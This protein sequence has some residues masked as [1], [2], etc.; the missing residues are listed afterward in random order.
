MSYAS[1]S[2]IAAPSRRTSAFWLT[3]LLFIVGAWAATAQE[4]KFHLKPGAQVK[5]CAECHPD[6]EETLK[7]PFVHSPVKAGACSDCHSPH[8]SDHGKL[9]SADVKQIC[10][11]CHA[12]IRPEAAR[13]IHAPVT[14]GDCTKCH[15]PHSAKNENNLP[16]AG[17]ELCFSCH[18]EMKKELA[19][20]TFKHSPVEKS[21][22]TCHDPHAST[23]SASL[24]KSAVP[25]L[26]TTC[27]K[28]A[29][30]AFTKAH[31]GYSVAKSD[32]T[33]CHDPHGSSSR[34]TLW[35]SVHQPV[36]SKMCGQCHV[37]PGASGVVKLK[38]SGADL[39]RSC[40]VEMIN[41]T[42]SKSRIHWPVIDKTACT[43]CHNPHAS[44]TKPLL[45]H[46]EAVLCGSCHR[47]AVQ[48]QVR[49]VTPHPPVADGECS[50][51]HSAHSS[52]ATYLLANE[53]VVDLCGTCHDWQRHSTHP[54]GAKIID[55]RNKNLS[56]G[57]L[58][59]HRSHG[60]AFKHLSPYDTK[61]DLCVQ[62]HEQLKR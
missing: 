4:N 7:Q 13:S 34:G 9:L 60:A 33:S 58:S 30:P 41:A 12:D 59:C 3:V 28:V 27:H 14:A 11:E 22:M 45:K 18:A 21:C 6:F 61:T 35:A 62:C 53:N 56:L 51:C 15:D 5:A 10:T 32:C 19:A 43:N 54:I 40:H 42:M 46:S 52:N 17:N 25:A 47:D 36:A 8:A 2:R 26:C 57:C 20:N 49:S 44:K 16:V 31:M 38:K 48:R 29:E 50:T 24:L 55:P 1:V 37:E 23:G 39:C